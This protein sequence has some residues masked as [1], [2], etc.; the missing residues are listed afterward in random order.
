VLDFFFQSIRAG[1]S[2][3]NILGRHDCLDLVTADDVKEM[4]LH[5]L[6]C[7]ASYRSPGGERKQVQCSER[8]FFFFFFLK[9]TLDVVSFF[10]II[11][12][13]IHYILVIKPYALA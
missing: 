5:V 11:L 12:S 9:D 2:R 4:G 8:A 3:P 6:T 7:T 10:M 13:L 1:P